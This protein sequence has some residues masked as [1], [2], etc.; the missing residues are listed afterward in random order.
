MQSIRA[1]VVIV[2]KGI[3]GLCLAWLLQQNG[4]D[5][6][7]LGRS[8]P[9]RA[10]ALA[11]TLP[12]SALVLLER[13][14]FRALFERS[15]LKKTLGYHSLWGTADVVDTNFFFHRPFQH[16]LKLDKQKLLL[17][18]EKQLARPAVAVD[19]GFEF[20]RANKALRFRSENG[21]GTVKGKVF[22]DATGRSRAL[23]KAMN[24]PVWEP[25][26]Q[27]AFSCHLPRIRHP[28]IKHDVFTELFGGGWGIVSGL[29]DETNVMTLF[30][31]KGTSLV[32]RMRDYTNWKGVLS[33]TRILK[34]FLVEG[35]RAKVIGAVANSSR[36][37]RIAGE[38]WLAVGD[39]AIAFDPL[40]SHGIT[41][42][43][44]CAWQAESAVAQA[45]KADASAPLLD[46]ANALEK[47]FEGYLEVRQQ[48]RKVNY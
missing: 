38:G 26:R 8:K 30:A 11:E 18:L 36:A 33:E 5:A 16:G 3:A 21:F 9:A 19:R 1:D 41:N 25:D 4:I 6:V 27:L 47:I 45:I 24:V 13:L 43:V 12:P 46:Y 39:A 29:D 17:E 10:L 34:A 20:H 40:S 31:E 28:R 23:L 7:L 32:R 35:I 48:L 22:V 15:A 37:E 2:G 44:Y 42:A 14:G